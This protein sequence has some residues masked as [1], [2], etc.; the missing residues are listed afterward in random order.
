MGFTL[1]IDEMRE[2]VRVLNN[3][4][5]RREFYTGKRGP[6]EYELNTY[7]TLR[8]LWDAYV[9]ERRVLGLSV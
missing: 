5:N 3:E 9:T 1:T 4:I 2:Q 7:P 6:N 8:P